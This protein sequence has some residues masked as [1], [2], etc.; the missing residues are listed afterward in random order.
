MRNTTVREIPKK[1]KKPEWTIRR[2]LK[3]QRHLKEATYTCSSTFLLN[4]V[5]HTVRDNWSLS[6]CA[7][8]LTLLDKCSIYSHFNSDLPA[9]FFSA[10]GSGDEWNITHIQKVLLSF[11]WTFGLAEGLTNIHT[12]KSPN[13]PPTKMHKRPRVCSLHQHLYSYGLVGVGLGRKRGWDEWGD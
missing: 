4:H 6:Q 7:K 5:E 9:M 10:V 12:P 2:V 3:N 1:K 13:K 8:L 11:L